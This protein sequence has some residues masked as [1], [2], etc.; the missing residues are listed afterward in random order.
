MISG[1][2]LTF[3]FMISSFLS[4]WGYLLPSVALIVL[5]GLLFPV[6]Y[7]TAPDK[8]VLRAGMIRRI[9]IP[10]ADITAVTPSSNGSGSSYALAKE[11][12]SI[13]YR[14]KKVF[15]APEERDPFITDIAMR[16]PHLSQHRT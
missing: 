14:G 8:L 1:F 6:S 2:T 15:V 9:R 4:Q 5:F 10:Y 11:K 7:E 13:E 16:S 12:L 3:L